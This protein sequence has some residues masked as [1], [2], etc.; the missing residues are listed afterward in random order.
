MSSRSSA[1]LREA[2]ARTRGTKGRQSGSPSMSE[3]QTQA[4]LAARDALRRIRRTSALLAGL[5][6][7]GL[8]PVGRSETPHRSD[9]GGV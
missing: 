2:S 1:S 7:T 6:K 9:A 3:M 4:Y 5:P 8:Q